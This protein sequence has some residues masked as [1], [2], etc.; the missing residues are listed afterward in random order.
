ME[1]IPRTRDVPFCLRQ[2]KTRSKVFRIA[3]SHYTGMMH[4]FRSGTVV[5]LGRFLAAATFALFI[6]AMPVF[7]VT[8]NVRWAVNEPRLYRYGFEKYEISQVMGLPLSELLRVGKEIRDYFNS[9]REPLDIRVNG[10][11][12]YNKREVLHMRDVKGLVRGV[13]W[14]QWVTGVYL[15]A[16]AL[17]GLVWKRKAFARL[18]GRGALWGGALTAGL[19][20]A[21]GVALA[22]GFSQIFY[23]FHIAS[24]RNPFWE[25]DPARDALVQ[26]FPEGFW[27]DATMFVALA[28]IV[29]ALLL[30]VIGALGL[31]LLG[32]ANALRAGK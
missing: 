30:A 25:L 16:F 15:L 12:L 24:F 13:Y 9:S 31:W 26:M 5:R 23:L 2:Q 10:R 32:K 21:A 6:L 11:S 29:E 28:T 17:V 14:T 1:L 8:T 3:S 19:L 18:L 7:L 22:V 20:L 4:V 27:F